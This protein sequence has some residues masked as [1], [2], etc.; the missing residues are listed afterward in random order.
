MLYRC[1]TAA[2]QT[3]WTVNCI[4]SYKLLTVLYWLD[5]MDFKSFCEYQ[6]GAS[7]LWYG[8]PLLE[9]LDW[10]GI[11]NE[12]KELEALSH[13]EALCLEPLR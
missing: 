6:L 12:I 9:P 11:L 3:I 5:I 13:R 1:A 4:D 2:A 10:E 7:A 8:N